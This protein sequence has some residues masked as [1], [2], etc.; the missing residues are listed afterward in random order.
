MNRL[1]R[2]HPLVVLVWFVCAV[3]VVAF[4]REP[5][6]LALCAAAVLPARLVCTRRGSR[7]RSTVLF[8]SVVIL[9]GL[10]NP[11]FSHKGA[12]PLLFIGSNAY[13]LESM[14]Y[15]VFAGLTITTVL[16]VSRVF[17]AC[18]DSDKLYYLTSKAGKKTGLLLSAS[19]R[20][21]PLFIKRARSAADG[22]RISGG[23]DEKRLTGRIRA[24][25]AVISSVAS[26][27]FEDSAQI[28][29]TMRSRGWGSPTAHAFYPISFKPGDAAALPALAALTA[30]ALLPLFIRGEYNF[31]PT[32][33]PLYAS[34][35]DLL[36]YAGAFVLCALPSVIVITEELKWKYLT[37]G[38]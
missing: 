6:T 12:T 31:Y 17:S 2:T 9:S 36:S 13:T 21:I 5:L 19:L 27:A 11:V 3:L 37:S 24:A 28:A 16:G 18:M 29:V 33:D 23:I 22:V 34:F 26:R 8:A 20:F 15:G 35:T 4:R 7:L 32:P 30:A 25:A 38:I 1:L 14:V 10:L